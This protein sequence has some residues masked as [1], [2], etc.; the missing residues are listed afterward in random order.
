[1]A[2]PRRP[3]AAIALV[4]LIGTSCS[5]APGETGGGGDQNDPPG[6]TPNPAELQEL[7]KKLP[8]YATCMRENGV[9]DFPDP[10]ADGIIQYYGDPDPLEFKSASEKCDDLLPE[11][12]GR[13]R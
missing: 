2:P 7:Q 10:G 1:M 8:E 13:N 9:E 6:A 3:L 5:N 11:D 4:A 12:R